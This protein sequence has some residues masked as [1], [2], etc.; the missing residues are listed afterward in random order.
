MVFGLVMSVPGIPGL[1]IVT[2]VIGSML[3]DFAEKRRWARWIISRPPILRGKR[4]APEVREA[5]AR[6][7]TSS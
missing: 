6:D 7:V 4:S 3:L 1:G 2:I 5:A